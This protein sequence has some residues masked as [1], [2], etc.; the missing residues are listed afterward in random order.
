MRQK[1]SVRRW[2]NF[3]P[4]KISSLSL[5]G[6]THISARPPKL[7]GPNH[8][9]L[10]G[11]FSSSALVILGGFAFRS[12]NSDVDMHVTW[13]RSRSYLQVTLFSLQ[14]PKISSHLCYVQQYSHVNPT[15]R[16]PPSLLSCQSVYIPSFPNAMKHRI[17]APRN[18]TVNTCCQSDI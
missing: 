13:L 11:R 8:A 5:A 12:G 7:S 10:V 2:R 4:E 18:K 16:R 1:L 6:T 17:I 3:R 14:I 9:I 15:I